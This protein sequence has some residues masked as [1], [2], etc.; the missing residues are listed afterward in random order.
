MENTDKVHKEPAKRKQKRVFKGGLIKDLSRWE[1]QK[2]KIWASF[3]STTCRKQFNSKKRILNF[4][5]FA[6]AKIGPSILNKFIEKINK[7]KF[8]ATTP[9][10]LYKKAICTTTLWNESW[11]SRKG[12]QRHVSLR[13]LRNSILSRANNLAHYIQ[14]LHSVV[15]NTSY[16]LVRDIK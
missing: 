1:I 8:I 11:R 16:L 13:Q 12:K 4:K 10:S 6:R 5:K 14:C 7:W 15:R 9:Q 3:L 2:H